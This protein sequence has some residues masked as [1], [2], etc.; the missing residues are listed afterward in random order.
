MPLI[1]LAVPLV[2]TSRIIGRSASVLVAS[3]TFLAAHATP[4]TPA[5]LAALPTVTQ[6]ERIGRE[7]WM[8]VGPGGEE[9]TVAHEPRL[10][11]GEFAVLREAALGGVGVA[12]LPEY[13]TREP[14]A[15]G[16]LERVLPGWTGREGILHLV[17]TSRRGLLPGVRAV[18]DFVAAVL[19]PR[20]VDWLAP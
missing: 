13:V 11:S 4:A 3:P 9:A 19:D 17:F 2:T 20:S 1:S 7:Q 18:I 5:E 8:L 12:L 10:A 16:R 15:D 6:S 14:I